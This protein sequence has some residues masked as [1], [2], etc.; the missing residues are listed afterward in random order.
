MSKEVQHSQ[1]FLDSV[2]RKRVFVKVLKEGNELV[3]FLG[4][5]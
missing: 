2:K 4:T 1:I 5:N 3:F